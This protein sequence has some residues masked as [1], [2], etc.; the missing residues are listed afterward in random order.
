MY[1]YIHTH[2]LYM[3]A[4]LTWTVLAETKLKRSQNLL[5][6]FLTGKRAEILYA[7]SLSFTSL[8]VK[9]KLLHT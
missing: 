1:T 6:K 5:R 2:I 8:L 7:N 9:I 4:K 3:D